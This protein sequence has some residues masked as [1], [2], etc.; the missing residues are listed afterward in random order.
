[1]QQFISNSP[2]LYFINNLLVSFDL[3]WIK[4]KPS[5][6]KL[7]HAC[8]REFRIW[9][10]T[11]NISTKPM[12]Y[13]KSQVSYSYRQMF[14]AWICDDLVIPT[15]HLILMKWMLKLCYVFWFKRQLYN[16]IELIIF[17]ILSIHAVI[18]KLLQL[19]LLA[20]VGWMNDIYVF[21]CPL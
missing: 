5:I 20:F 13:I 8:H 2:Q 17:L 4:D 21:C 3:H 1:M 14:W 15:F 18:W 10:G 16:Q 7:I 11:E 6:A 9:N 12:F 19:H